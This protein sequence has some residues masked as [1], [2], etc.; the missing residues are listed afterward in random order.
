MHVLL[1]SVLIG[2]LAATL[3]F[4]WAYQKETRLQL[5]RSSEIAE[6]H[7]PALAYALWQFDKEQ[8]S[9]IIRGMMKHT[10]LTYVR[11]T[12]NSSLTVETG[13]RPYHT[14]VEQ[15]PLRYN[16]VDVGTLEIA[17]SENSPV[18]KAASH[19]LPVISSIT[20]MLVA[21]AILLFYVIHRVVTQRISR[22]AATVD[23][24]LH[25]GIHVP[26]NV[27][28]SDYNDEI[29]QLMVSFRK[30]NEELLDELA[31]NTRTQQQ[32]GL[33]N[34]ELEQR[35]DERTRHLSQTIGRLN[36]TVADLNATQ[37]QLIEAER[38]SALG[39]M[40]AAIGHEIETPLGLCLTMESCLRND[41]L[42]LQEQSHALTLSL[43]QDS[44]NTASLSFDAVIESLDL[45]RENLRRATGLMKGFK[46]VT[47][48]QIGDDSEW[49][50]LREA[51][52][53]LIYSLS[54]SLRHTRHQIHLSCAEHI[55]MQASP[56][57]INQILTN[58][59][60]NSLN[61]G[62]QNIPAGE[63]SIQVA[64]DR[65]NIVIRYSDNGSGLSDEAKGKIFEPLFTTKRG[66][67]GTGLGMH[68]VYNIIQQR[69]K[70]DISLEDTDEGVAFRISIPKRKAQRREKGRRAIYHTD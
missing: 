26:I 31:R 65:E 30:L 35:V 40:I 28:P 44:E 69:M 38:L 43:K 62:F 17:F 9:L 5:E 32:L 50:N 12:D 70:G 2:G 55:S 10:S 48:G 22:L 67:G 58:L 6:S 1:T 23:S 52:N 34:S 59:I 7:S 20:A 13:S 15:I 49:I 33:A 4:F 19:A 16:N 51:I 68:L 18:T 8:M 66:K 42:E 14:Q 29:D 61:H 39:G 36:Q 46:S 56:M 53:Q 45:L 54:P 11:A 63:I 37:G 41:L 64:E 25:N 60:M 47:A 57:A 21:L 27:E 3:L 24:R